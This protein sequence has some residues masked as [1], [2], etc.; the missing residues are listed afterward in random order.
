MYSHNNH[1]KKNCLKCF[2]SCWIQNFAFLYIYSFLDFTLHDWLT[3]RLICGTSVCSAVKYVVD[4]GTSQ[5]SISF[6]LISE[7][8]NSSHLYV[9]LYVISIITNV[10]INLHLKNLHNLLSYISN[11]LVINC[12]QEAIT[13]LCG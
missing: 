2:A 13:L 7:K 8:L 10:F 11:A 3:C 4:S 12:K 5:I 6:L 9:C 1:Q